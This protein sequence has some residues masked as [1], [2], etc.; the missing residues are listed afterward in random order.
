LTDDS[1][2]SFSIYLKY[3][4]AGGGCASLFF[5]LLS[6]VAFQFVFSFSHYWLSTWTRVEQLRDGYDVKANNGNTYFT[7]AAVN[8]VTV[9]QGLDV[10]KGMDTYT[11]IYGFAILVV[12]GF[13][14]SIIRSIHFFVIFFNAS[15]RLHDKMFQSV[16]RSPLLFFDRNP[17]G[18][19]IHLIFIFKCYWLQLSNI[20]RIFKVEY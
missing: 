20:F 17:I 11:G 10:L 5:F 6:C 3:F 1:A 8:N 13:A 15:I 12:C 4:N 18:A 19:F 7:S 2:V 9:T 16:V 14:F